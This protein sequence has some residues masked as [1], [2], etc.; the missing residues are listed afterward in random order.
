[1]SADNTDMTYNDDEG[2][3]ICNDKAIILIIFCFVL[4]V[5]R[6]IKKKIKNFF[7]K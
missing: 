2:E 4:S 3:T 7:F 6:R 1:M 5:A